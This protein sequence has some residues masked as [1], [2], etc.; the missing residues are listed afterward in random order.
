[1]IS[2]IINE[3]ISRSTSHFIKGIFVLILN[4]FQY[5]V[6]Q[7]IFTG[8]PSLAI[9]V[10]IYFFQHL[11]FALLT[12][13]YSLLR[14][15]LQRSSLNVWP[16]FWVTWYTTCFSSMMIDV[17]NMLIWM[18]WKWAYRTY[19]LERLLPMILYILHAKFVHI[20]VFAALLY[21]WK[22]KQVLW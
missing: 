16:V 7:L 4:L 17:L 11:F 1:M 8:L 22:E 3:Y 9:H 20:F 14:F 19:L 13:N 21:W 2:R 15:R 6:S 10:V 5:V 12:N 18:I